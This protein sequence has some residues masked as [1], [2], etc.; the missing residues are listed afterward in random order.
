MESAILFGN[1]LNRAAGNNMSWEDLL[2]KLSSVRDLPSDSNTLNYECIYLDLCKGE[3]K[4]EKGSA[5]EIEYDLK[6]KIAKACSSFHAGEIYEK[7]AQLPVHVYLTTNY[8]GV[9][10]RTLEKMGYNFDKDASCMTETL[11]SIR[12]CHAYQKTLIE[13]SKR[14]FPIHGEYA[15]PKSIMI[16]YDHYCGSLGKLDDFFKGNYAYQQN[17]QVIKLPKL[18]TRL[19]DEEKRL[20]MGMY[21][22][23]YFFTH[24][25]H[26]IGLSL[27]L[28]E[29]D[30][31]WVLNKRS[32]IMHFTDSIR[33]EIYFY[34]DP[35]KQTTKLLETFGVNVVRV[36]AKEPKGQAEWDEAYRIMMAEMQQRI[37][38]YR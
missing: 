30:L 26:I 32:R 13:P 33:N 18:T 3:R 9:L 6:C 8:D 38:T 21:W 16:G 25:I 15:A 7:L 22:P 2:K 24:N 29:T 31:W 11:Y 23:D 10:D 4:Y 19:K 1:G 35:D 5:V 20:D 27:Q 12:R 17:E 14:I 28:V 36:A 34:G 37:K